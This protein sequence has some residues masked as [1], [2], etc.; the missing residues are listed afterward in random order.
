MYGAALYKFHDVLRVS[1]ELY[2]SAILGAALLLV[3]TIGVPVRIYF[4]TA[5]SFD[6]ADIGRQFRL[7]FS[8]LFLMDLLWSAVPLLFLGQ[9]QGMVLLC[10]GALAFLPLSQRTLLYSAYGRSGG[11]SSV[12]L[13]RR[14]MDTK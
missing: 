12:F 1:H 14:T 2:G 6:F 10:A 13:A 7:V 4:S 3:A 8:F 11:R 5:L 9:L